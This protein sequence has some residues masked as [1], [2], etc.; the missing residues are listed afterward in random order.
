MGKFS[1][2]RS[3]PFNPR[4]AIKYQLDSTIGHHYHLQT[5]KVIQNEWWHKTW[6]IIGGCL[7]LHLTHSRRVIRRLIRRALGGTSRRK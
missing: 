3:L 4:E 2:Q 7:E 1:I 5:R 6:K